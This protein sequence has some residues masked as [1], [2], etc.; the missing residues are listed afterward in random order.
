[1]LPLY[2]LIFEEINE[3]GRL[4]QIL[5]NNIERRIM[6]DESDPFSFS[7]NQFKSLYRLTKDMVNHLI[8]QLLPHMNNSPHPNAVDPTLRIFAASFFLQ[9][10]L[11]NES[12]GIVMLYQWDKQQ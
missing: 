6:R 1:M 8:Q 11:I 7:D 3:D 4:H 10:V 2:R 9:M 5:Q 12:L